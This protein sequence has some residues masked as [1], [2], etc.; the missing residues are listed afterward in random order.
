MQPYDLIPIQ[1]VSYSD[2]HD[3][4]IV[5][6]IAHCMGVDFMEA[7]TLLMGDVS[8]HY[9][10]PQLTG[11]E[12]QQQ[13]PGFFAEIPFAYPDRVPVIQLVPLEKQAWHA[14]VSVFANWNSLPECDKGLNACTVGIEFHMPGYGEGRHWYRFGSLTP[15]QVETGIALVRHVMQTYQIPNRHYL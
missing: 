9:F 15:L 14:G 10:V 5:G 8:A 12:L 2:R 6:V 4:P 13:Y 7:L 11:H 3:C 1:T